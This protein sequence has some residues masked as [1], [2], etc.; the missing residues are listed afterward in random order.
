MADRIPTPWVRCFAQRPGAA[1]TLLCFPHAGGAASS[2]RGWTA[3]LPEDVEQWVVQYPGREDR[4]AHAVVDEMDALVDAVV[5]AVEPALGDR[6]VVVFGHSMGA[7]VA[8]EVVLRLAELRPGL[9]RRL[10]VSGRPGPADQKPREEFVHLRDDAGVTAELTALGGTAAEAFADPQLAAMLLPVI[11]NDFAL[12]ERYRPGG[13]VLD[14]EVV[15][16]TGD[17]DPSMAAETVDS[18][19]AAT[20]GPF[21]R[22]VH[23]GGHFYLYD[24]LPAVVEA[25]LAPERGAGVSS[26]AFSVEGLRASVAEVLGVPVEEVG[27][28]TGLFELGLDS[29]R[30][31]MLSVRW[32]ALG[33]EAPFADLAENPTVRAWS[34]LLSA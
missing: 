7:S 2:Y 34:R 17:A 12:I 3:H 25:A 31:M 29:M 22:H 27:A 15:A 14:L 33:V 10:V 8:H 4:I 28:D 21:T 9:V 16:I 13:A 6:P 18:W 24:H 30:M 32:Q 19:A 23:P 11:R 20:T 5:A 1:R 26:D